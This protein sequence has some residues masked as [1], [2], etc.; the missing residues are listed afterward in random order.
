MDD[1]KWFD[2]YHSDDEACYLE[3][4]DK[5]QVKWGGMLKR[6]ADRWPMQAC[7]KGTMK[8]IRPKVVI[9][10]SNYHPEEIWTDA[11]TLDPLL[12]RFNVI[13]KECQEQ[14]IDFT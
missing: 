14:E 5:Y 4:L 2:N 8:Y 13:L 10:T 12:R 7:I 9:V 11:A 6:L 1:L 3:D